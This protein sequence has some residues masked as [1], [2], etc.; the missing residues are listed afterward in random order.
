MQRSRVLVLGLVLVVGGGLA[1]AQEASGAHPKR[2]GIFTVVHGVNISD[3]AV[4][5]APG[6]LVWVLRQAKN[7]TVLDGRQTTVMVATLQVTRPP[8]DDLR[9]RH[10]I[11]SCGINRTE[12]AEKAQLG[13]ARPLVS[14]APVD[15]KGDVD[16]NA[17][18]PYTQALLSAVPS[19]RPS[20]MKPRIL[21][22]GDVPS[23]LTPPA[24]C[25]FHTRCPKAM[26]QCKTA[27][28]LWKDVG[29]GHYTAYH[30]S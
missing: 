14:M 28:P 7:V 26:R 24:G 18:C 8:F 1:L 3:F 15:T 11:G 20:V 9:V 29:N 30:L 22:S 27:E 23:P 12:S 25:R 6:Y 21:L 4:Q 16:L 5:A 2:R 17:L 13:F 19:A 10:V